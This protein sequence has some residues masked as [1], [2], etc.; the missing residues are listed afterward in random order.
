MRSEKGAHAGYGGS[1]LEPRLG[2]WGTLDGARSAALFL[3]RGGDPHVASTASPGK[4]SGV[5]GFNGP[6]SPSPVTAPASA[7][8]YRSFQ[9]PSSPCLP[10]QL[11]TANSAFDKN[12]THPLTPPVIQG[13]YYHVTYNESR[14][15]CGRRGFAR[16]DSDAALDKSAAHTGCGQTETQN[17]L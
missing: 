3:Q 6:S 4:Q 1:G 13:D 17:C 9:L 11:P 5:R 7:P 2:G 14:D 8:L 10:V 15:L 16:K 12:C